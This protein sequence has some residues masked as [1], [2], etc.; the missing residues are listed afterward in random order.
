MWRYLVGAGGAMLLVVAGL[1]LF[2]GSASTEKRLLPAPSAAVASETEQDLPAEPPSAAAKTREQKRFD[3]IDKDKNDT[4]TKDE[5]FALRRKLFARLDTDHDGRLSFEEWS[6][7][8]VERFAGADKDKSGTL[9]RPEF[10]TTAVKRTA[11]PRCAC[12]PA[13]AAAKP[14]DQEP[15]EDSDG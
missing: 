8:A 4:I 3:R 6:V 9:S 15:A 7:K 11:K 5:F 12:A 13:K 2:R 10:A 1:F 14:A